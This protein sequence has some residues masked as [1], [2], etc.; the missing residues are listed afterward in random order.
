MHVYSAVG[1]DMSIM[2]HLPYTDIV[3]SSESNQIESGILLITIQ[4]GYQVCYQC[5]KFFNQKLM[6]NEC[7]LS[8]EDIVLKFKANLMSSCVFTQVS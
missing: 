2:P 7:I 5:N 1:L 8:S 3:T 4:D 6:S